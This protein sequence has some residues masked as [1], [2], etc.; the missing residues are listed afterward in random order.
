[1]R[2]SWFRI[3]CRTFLRQYDTPNPTSKCD[4]PNL[5]ETEG[6]DDTGRDDQKR[7]DDQ[8]GETGRAKTSPEDLPTGSDRQEE[9]GRDDRPEV[10]D[11]KRRPEDTGRDGRKAK[12]RQEEMVNRK[13]H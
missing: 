6:R 8:P 2:R 12:T 4:T 9:T 7:Q 3:G 13:R 10:I 5:K 1:M 11:K